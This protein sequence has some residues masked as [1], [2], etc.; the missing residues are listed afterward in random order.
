MTKTSP[1]ALDDVARPLSAT[2]LH[3]LAALLR[4]ASEV[5]TRLASSTEKKAARATGPVEIHPVYRDAGAPEGAL[6]IN[7]ELVGYISGVTRL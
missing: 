3:L 5:L 4:G 2:L 1:W 7:G 6:Y